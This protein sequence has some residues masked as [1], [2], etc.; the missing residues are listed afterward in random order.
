MAQDLIQLNLKFQ[1]DIG[2]K[3]EDFGLVTGVS[4]SHSRSSPGFIYPGSSGSDPTNNLGFWP[5]VTQTG[6]YS[7]RSRLEA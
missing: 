5:V 1:P 6:L 7:H 4:D 2:W 3:R